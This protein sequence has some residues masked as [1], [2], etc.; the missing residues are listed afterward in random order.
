MV[1][2]ERV[3]ADVASA[4]SERDSAGRTIIEVPIS[5]PQ[6]PW[7]EV[8]GRRVLNLCSNDYLGLAGDPRVRRVAAD[9][10]DQ[11]GFGFAAGRIISGTSVVHRELEGELSRFL[12]TDDA[13]LLTSCFDANLGLFEALAGPE[14]VIISDALNHA[15]IIDGIRLSKATR[16]TYSTRDLDELERA[17][18]DHA[19]ARRR[20]IVTDGVFSMDGGIAPLGG[21]CDLAE[22]YDAIVIVDDSH[23]IGVTG[24][25]GAG[26]T[27]SSEVAG[28]VDVVTGTLGK[29]LGGAGGGFIAGGR[30]TIA[31]LR[32]SARPYVFSNALPPAQVEVARH[33]LRLLSGDS[34][35]LSRL[36]DNTGVLWTA[37]DRRGLALAPGNHPIV[38]VLLGDERLA[39]EAAA[40]LLERGVLCV[41]LTFPVVEWSRA[42]LRLQVSAAHDPADLER[43]A[44]LVAD[45]VADLT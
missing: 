32:Q 22:R 34:G 3:R 13:M 19:P 15:S 5:G 27:V 44:D 4:L 45:V 6:G 37:L 38:P 33:A 23:G 31:L 43:A 2:S 21:I 14:D 17:L 20:L 7:I 25:G 29:A 26:V 30:E 11:N 9:A 8:S 28:R 18:V 24:V 10:I 41:A 39:N 35:L 42:R 1:M 12:G 36:A 40:A 16:A